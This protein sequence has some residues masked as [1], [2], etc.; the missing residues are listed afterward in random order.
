[1]TDSGQ[2]ESI[3][4]ARQISGKICPFCGSTDGQIRH[5]KTASGSQRCMCLDYKKTY[6]ID[7]KR[8]RYSEE[9][10]AEAIAEYES[11]L[12]VREIAR[13]H[14]MCKGNVSNWLSKCGGETG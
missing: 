8:I 12:S 9:T 14:N 7:P 13:K 6:T 1:M 2:K 11:G 5:G 10:K 4:T 3:K